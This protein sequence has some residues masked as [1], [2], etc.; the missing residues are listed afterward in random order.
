MKNIYRWHKWIGVIAGTPL[1]IWLVSGIVLTLPNWS[2]TTVGNPA[3]PI[4]PTSVS[5]TPA[6]ALSAAAQDTGQPFEAK[7]IKLLQTVAGPVYEIA[8]L[9]GRAH[10][11]D[12][13]TGQTVT[14]DAGMAELI[15]RHATGRP[16][17]PAQ[18]RKAT[19]HTLAYPFGPLPT[20]RLAFDDDPSTYY[21]THSPIHRIRRSDRLGRANFLIGSFHT[22]EPLR[23]AVRNVHY[24][25]IVMIS[26]ALLGTF[27]V[28]TG[29]YMA[30][31]TR[32]RNK[33]PG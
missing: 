20:Y 14:M 6:H 21:F 18:V 11:I 28:L 33:I 27:S 23:V 26:F 1:L 12:A 17:V 22:F 24:V 4:D 32:R 5:V 16:D 8:P 2:D 3:Q 15:I 31:P 7:Y 30:L 10:L 9:R 19:K 29:F 25:H 13:A